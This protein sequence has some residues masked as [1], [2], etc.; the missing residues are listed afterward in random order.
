MNALNSLHDVTVYVNT[1]TNSGLDA[2]GNPKARGG[3]TDGM[4]TLM[5]E[6]GPEL[7]RFPDGRI[8][9]AST[10]GIYSV[11]L[12]TY[13]YTAPKTRA[14]FAD[15][16]IPGYAQGGYVRPWRASAPTS[17]PL[18]G[19]A[20]VHTSTVVTHVYAV[21]SDELV[22]LIDNAQ[23]GGDLA[24]NLGPALTQLRQTSATPF[25]GRR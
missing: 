12:G 20:T 4:L 15:G 14:M 25:V 24:R 18:R 16:D 10:K 11:P 1:I 5:A 3:Y 23:A 2:V 7:L 17:A 13:V 19:S 8:G 9:M 22:Q 21:K 6:Q